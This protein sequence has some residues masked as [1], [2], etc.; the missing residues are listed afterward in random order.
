MDKFQM[1]RIAKLYYELD[2][3]QKEIAEMENISRSKVSRILTRAKDKGL[4]ELRVKVSHGSVYNLE[5]ELINK[6]ALKAAII[7][8]VIINNENIILKEIGQAAGEFLIDIVSDEDILGVSWGTTMSYVADN[9]PENDIKGV[10]IVQLNGGMSH[11]KLSTTSNTIVREFVQAFEGHPYLM[12]VPAIVDSKKIVDCLMGDRKINHIFSLCKKARVAIFGIGYFS[13]KSV[14]YKAGYFEGDNSFE[15]LEK[16]GAVG[17][18]IARYFDINGKICNKELNNR[19]IGVSLADLR[20]TEYSIGV[21]SGD[22]KIEAI[23]GALSGGY[24]NTLITD[25]NTARQILD[26]E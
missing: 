1:I 13:K 9:L 14:L 11:S 24:I 22:E 15:Q 23:I 17:D 4:I 25:E 8:P 5:R 16:S 7:T 12:P 6:F 26:F 3:T 18:V 20:K 21:A 2:K 10:K 19:T